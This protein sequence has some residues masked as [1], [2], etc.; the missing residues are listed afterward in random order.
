MHTGGEALHRHAPMTFSCIILW[1][2]AL[3]VVPFLIVDWAT[4]SRSERIRRLR[5]MGWSQQRIADH[6]GVTRYRVRQALA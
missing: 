4:C 3:L 6:L 1:A 5:A 2:L